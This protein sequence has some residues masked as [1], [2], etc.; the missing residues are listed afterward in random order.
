MVDPARLFIPP[1]N[2]RLNLFLPS[3]PLCII[4]TCK[5]LEEESMLIEVNCKCGIR[6]PLR[7]VAKHK[8]KYVPSKICY[9]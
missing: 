3:A 7:V 5:G 1:E 9:F 4:I 2:G 8:K 6:L